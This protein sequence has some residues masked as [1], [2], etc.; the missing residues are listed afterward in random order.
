MAKTLKAINT[1]EDAKKLVAD[2][3]QGAQ[4]QSNQNASILEATLNEIK[5]INPQLGG[6]EGVAAL[7]SLSEEHF[8]LLAPA[9]LQEL[10]KSYNNVNDQLAL[11]QVMNAAG[12]RAE[13]VQKEYLTIC[14][15]IDNQMA[16]TLSRPKRD[17][18]KRILGLTYNTVSEANGIAKRS[19]LIP[20]EY[21]RTDAKMPA[22][23]HGTDAGMDIYATEDFTINPGETKLIPIG[24]KTAIPS[25]Y[26]LLIHPRSGLSLKTK[27]R[28]CN[29]IGLIDAGYRDEIGV[30]VEN[31]ESPVKDITYHFDD[32]GKLIL[33]SILHGSPIHIGKGEKFAQM[34][35]VEVPKAVFYEVE[36][37]DKIP[38]DGRNG[39]FGSSDIG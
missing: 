7:L 20:I 3:A 1:P 29:S 32:N 34:R 8:A 35:L 14:E 16:G 30:I 12:I 13:D 19:I 4:E 21:C 6:F 26:A 5:N 36:S 22:Y 28:V 15:E 37:V 17:F 11:V 39:G 25:G 9:F 18:L 2:M 33:D 27:M 24:I 23:A 10:E 31:I 38:N